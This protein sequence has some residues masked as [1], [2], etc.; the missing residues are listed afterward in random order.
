MSSP[1]SD[2]ETCGTF[3]PGFVCYDRDLEWNE[4]NVTFCGC[5][6]FYGFGLDADSGLCTNREA[7][8]H[9]SAVLTL[10]SLSVAFLAFVVGSV[11]LFRLLRIQEGRLFST[12]NTTAFL[13]NVTLLLFIVWRINFIL[14]L[15]N[16]NEY[17]EFPFEDGE[18][19]STFTIPDRTLASITSLF[20]TLTALNI[21]L[22]WLDVAESSRRFRQRVHTN[23]SKYRITIYVFQV[24]LLVLIVIFQALNYPFLSV[25]AAMPFLFFVVVTYIIG[26]YKMVGLLNVAGLTVSTG[27][28][29]P[30]ESEPKKKRGIMSRMAS[31]FQ[32]RGSSKESESRYLEMLRLIVLTTRGLVTALTLLFVFGGI[33]AITSLLGWKEYSEPGKISLTATAFDLFAVSMLFAMIIVHFYVYKNLQANINRIKGVSEGDS[34]RELGSGSKTNTQFVT[35]SPSM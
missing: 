27:P 34:S 20:A 5:I 24:L 29:E 8:W 26:Q 19:L 30:V 6:S 14:L 17:N 2:E 3:P 11:S 28:A 25:V 18:R 33:F 1:C 21:S 4:L 31:S 9:L 22:L 13:A 16:P 10:I 15:F 7:Q 35:E 23:F 32:T 12:H